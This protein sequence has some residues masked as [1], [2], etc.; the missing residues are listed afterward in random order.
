MP[1]AAAGPDPLPGTGRGRPKRDTRTTCG[2]APHSHSGT[3]H[4][5]AM[6]GIV[7]LRFV[8]QRWHRISATAGTSISLRPFVPIGAKTIPVL[9]QCAKCF[10]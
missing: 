1:P 8:P 5:R 4:D 3:S 7:V 9:D 10:E 6:P 2:R